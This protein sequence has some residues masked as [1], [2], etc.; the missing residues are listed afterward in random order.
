[1]SRLLLPCL[2]AYEIGQ[3]LIGA[4]AWIG[5]RDRI[6]Q[7][8]NLVRADEDTTTHLTP[9]VRRAL[10]RRCQ[11]QVGDVTGGWLVAWT[12]PVRELTGWPGSAAAERSNSARTSRNM[13]AA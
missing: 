8:E 10:S 11:S 12:S 1:M 3:R 5:V 9:I 2:L 4:V 6:L 7:A 13:I